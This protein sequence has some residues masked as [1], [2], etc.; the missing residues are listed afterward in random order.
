MNLSDGRSCT[1]PG[2]RA[3]TVLW[4]GVVTAYLLEGLMQ[5][6]RLGPRLDGLVAPVLFVG[7]TTFA[8]VLTALVPALLGFLW[9]V[10]PGK[11]TGSRRGKAFLLALMA[12]GAAL[13]A[14]RV[15]HQE[16]ERGL[17]F[18]RRR[19]DP[20]VP[21]ELAPAARPLTHVAAWLVVPTLILAWVLARLMALRARLEAA[22]WTTRILLAAG[23]GL[24]MGA[25]LWVDESRYVNLYRLIHGALSVVAVFLGALA[26]GLCPSAW[27]DG[28]ARRLFSG[29]GLVFV[30]VTALA[31][32]GLH[33][34]LE[35]YWPV[36]ALIYQQ[37][38]LTRETLFVLRRLT[39]RDGDGA[40]AVLGGDDA[41]DRDPLCRPGRFEVAGNGYDE[42]GFEGDLPAD[43]VPVP[44]QPLP[45]PKP[46]APVDRVILVTIDALRADRVGKM[47]AEGAPLT[48]N[49]SQLAARGV[50]FTRA[51]SHASYTVFCF[52]SIWSSW[53]PYALSDGKPEPTWLPRYLNEAGIDTAGIATSFFGRVGFERAGFRRLL[54]DIDDSRNPRTAAMTLTEALRELETP[55][56]KRFLWVHF[57]DV[58]GPYAPVNP[59]AG[60]GPKDLYDAEIRATDA[61]IGR[62]LQAINAPGAPSTAIV[63]TADHGEEFGEHDAAYHGSTL[64]EE[65]THVPLI[66]AAP[67][68]QRRV[69]GRVVRHIDLAPT[70]TDLLGLSPSPDWMGRSLLTLA[71]GNEDP[72]FD[73]GVM[74]MTETG[75]LSFIEPEGRWK[76]ITHRALSTWELYDLESDPREIR[77]LAHPSSKRLRTMRRLLERREAG[78][79]AFL[80]EVRRRRR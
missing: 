22:R 56:G 42:N 8:G 23:V 39:D 24:L 78:V 12:L 59:A 32:G 41:D 27:I 35:R 48:P 38:N 3:A 74:A 52:G 63:L 1:S 18:L 47:D 76:I 75:L 65:V 36:E 72:D 61:A 43:Q 70:I 69:E 19:I 51:F 14:Y 40:P 55:R 9:G 71:L 4:T 17:L 7:A 13:L 60:A 44:P 20:D 37:S 30:G 73:H 26:W 2:L 25:V 34:I 54:T 10:L 28:L 77:N 57:F 68:L 58:H 66:I 80:R 45:R 64:Y 50:R 6:W 29:V 16:I 15:G 62:L 49:I 33:V 46:L 53:L 79:E 67:Q 21:Y 11:S 5:T 31:G